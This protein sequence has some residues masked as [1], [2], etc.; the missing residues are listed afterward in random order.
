MMFSLF[1][2]CDVRQLLLFRMSI[3]RCLVTFCTTQVD[4]ARLEEPPDG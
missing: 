3:G 2:C 4:S 1:R